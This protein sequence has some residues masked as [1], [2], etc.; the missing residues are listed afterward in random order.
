MELRLNV[1]D[2]F[3]EK[4]KNGI[5]LV[6]NGKLKVVS[7]ET[8]TNDLRK[9]IETSEK[10]IISLKNKIHDQDETIKELENKLIKVLEVFANE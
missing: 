2:K 8:L 1:D 6:D 10:T 3:L 7:I 4:N 9:Q 5:I